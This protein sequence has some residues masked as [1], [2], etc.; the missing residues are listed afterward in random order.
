MRTV[1]V[2]HRNISIGGA[3]IVVAEYE[4]P[5]CWNDESRRNLEY[6]DLGASNTKV[7]PGL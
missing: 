5:L 7:L 4:V 3:V 1:L 6:I 2:V